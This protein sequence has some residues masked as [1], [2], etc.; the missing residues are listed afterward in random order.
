VFY[1]TITTDHGSPEEDI[2]EED[3][4]TLVLNKLEELPEPRAQGLDD[5]TIQSLQ[6]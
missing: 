3:L 5:K 6:G 2:L 1:K 4:K